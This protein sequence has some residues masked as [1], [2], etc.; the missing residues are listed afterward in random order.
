M[1]YALQAQF[2]DGY[3]YTGNQEDISVVDPDRNA[4]FDIKEGL[5]REHGKITRYTMLGLVKGKD[6]RYARYDIDFTTLPESVKPIWYIKREL[7]Q[8]YA[9]DG[10]LVDVSETRDILYGFGYEFTN[11]EGKV[12]KDIMEVI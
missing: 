7:D 5:Q 11:S 9:S 2:E 1:R 10:E 4:F 12:E 6:N 8:N 3:E